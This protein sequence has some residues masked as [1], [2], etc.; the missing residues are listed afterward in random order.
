MNSQQYQ[1]ALAMAVPDSSD[2]E[3]AYSVASVPIQRLP[4]HTSVKFYTP[5]LTCQAE[6]R[7][8]YTPFTLLY[9]KTELLHEWESPV[10]A[11]AHPPLYIEL[12][13][14]DVRQQ[15]DKLVRLD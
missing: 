14:G 13:E 11:T 12:Q 5:V 1:A 7:M 15:L 4:R 3:S 6:C 8:S 10:S 9:E 2:E